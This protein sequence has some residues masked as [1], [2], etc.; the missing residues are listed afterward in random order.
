MGGLVAV[1]ARPRDPPEA[2]DH[3]QPI[4]ARPLT[5]ELAQRLDLRRTKGRL[6]SRKAILSYSRSRS[7]KAVPRFAF[8]RS[9]SSP[10]PVLGV[11]VSAASPRGGEDISPTTQCRRRH[12]QASRNRFEAL[13]T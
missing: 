12:A 10:S 1:D 13:A 4:R 5:G 9:L 8:N 7:I 11:V 6:A 3:G 2:T